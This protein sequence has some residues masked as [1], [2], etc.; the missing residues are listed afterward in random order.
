MNGRSRRIADG[1]HIRREAIDLDGVLLT[2]QCDP[3]IAG[4]FDI[5]ILHLFPM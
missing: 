5:H 1:Q 2:D 4:T 3:S